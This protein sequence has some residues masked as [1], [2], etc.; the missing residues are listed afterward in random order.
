[1][2]IIMASM[3]F[4]V[5]IG[6]L[7]IFFGSRQQGKSIETTNP[8]CPPK[9]DNSGRLDEWRVANKLSKLPQEYI[10]FN[11][12]LFASLNK[13]TQIDHLVISPYGIFVIETKGHHG[14]ITGNENEAYWTQHLN[15]NKYKLY[16]PVLQNQ[17]HVNATSFHLHVDKSL[18]TSIVVFTNA[19]VKVKTASNILTLS[20]LLSFI[21]SSQTQIVKPNVINR[22][23]T[24][25]Y[26]HNK[27]DSPEEVKKH[28]SRVKTIA[29]Y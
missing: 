14:L 4:S 17:S 18:I 23:I 21:T 16:N 15:S 25:A 12:L 20:Q 9:W 2:W 28:I 7:A 11:N 22:A 13:S 6:A 8:T 24:N 1:M 10:I 26:A 29:A 19:T 3:A 27:A 5:A